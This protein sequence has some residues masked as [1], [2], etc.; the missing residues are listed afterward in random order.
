MRLYL[1]GLLSGLLVA[2]VVGVVACGPAVGPGD[3]GNGN[4][5]GIKI[6]ALTF[7]TITADCADAVDGV[8]PNV[9]TV[10]VNGVDPS[11]VVAARVASETLDGLGFYSGMTFYKKGEKVYVACAGLKGKLSIRVGVE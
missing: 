9:K 11:K 1:F 7:K 2:A 3:G 8:L 6:G 10:E 4:D 5:I